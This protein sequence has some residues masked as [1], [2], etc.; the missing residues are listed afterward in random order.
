M[1]ACV[2]VCTHVCVHMCVRVC[3]FMCARVCARVG[4]CSLRECNKE[5]DSNGLGCGHCRMTLQCLLLSS[6]WALA[7]RR[8]TPEGIGLHTTGAVI[9]KVCGKQ[10]ECILMC[11]TYGHMGG[12]GRSRH[13]Y[14]QNG[15]ICAMSDAHCEEGSSKSL[16][17]CACHRANGKCVVLI[18][19]MSVV[20][21][22]M[23][24]VETGVWSCSAWRTGRR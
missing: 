20:V 23:V 5:L 22:L 7:P 21:Y 4:H 24:M 12:N 8:S 17:V 6:S 1:R 11:L 18:A 2:S 16:R 9:S 14:R 15:T 19:C 13:L 10:D 3:V